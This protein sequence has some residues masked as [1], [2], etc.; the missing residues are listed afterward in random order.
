[1]KNERKKERKQISESKKNSSS[2][3][4]ADVGINAKFKPVLYSRVY[5][6]IDIHS[7]TKTKYPQK[8]LSLFLER[9]WMKNYWISTYW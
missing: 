5:W 9:K 7:H 4:N 8:E 1:M 2:A 3:M 6:E